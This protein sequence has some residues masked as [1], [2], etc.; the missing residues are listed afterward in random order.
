MVD[1]ADGSGVTSSTG[2]KGGGSFSL[3]ELGPP[4]VDE[5][6]WIP[7]SVGY[8]DVAR[9][10]F[11]VETGSPLP[12]EGPVEPPLLATW[13]GR[14][15]YLLSNGILADSGAG[16]GNVLTLAVLRSLPKRDGPR[17]VYGA[18]CTLGRDRLTREKITF[19]QLPYSLRVD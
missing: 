13:G 4:L 19:R 3:C 7:K 17:I 14:S 12:R 16:S 8:A 10:V 18:G 15:I 11:F 6:G 5:K 1:G 2:W 9:L